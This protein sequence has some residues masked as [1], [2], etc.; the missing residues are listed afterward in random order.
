MNPAAACGCPDEPGPGERLPP[1]R[2]ILWDATPARGVDAAA[3]C[4][5]LRGFP[6]VPPLRA[7][8]RLVGLRTGRSQWIC[9]RCLPR[10]PGDK[11]AG[12]MGSDCSAETCET[13]GPA[14]DKETAA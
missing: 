6:F 10:W 13:P 3:A 12:R 7:F 9:P 11:S 2:R 14:A 5:R 4:P 1:R 8:A